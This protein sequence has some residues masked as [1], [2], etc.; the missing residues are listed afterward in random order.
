MP[1]ESPTEDAEDPGSGLDQ[2]RLKAKAK[3]EALIPYWTIVFK[4]PATVAKKAAEW[5]IDYYPELFSHATWVSIE[6]NDL[7]DFQAGGE[8]FRDSGLEIKIYQKEIPKLK[9][10]TLKLGGLIGLKSAGLNVSSPVY[11]T[12]GGV[13]VSAGIGMVTPYVNFGKD[14]KPVISFSAKVPLDIF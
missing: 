1:Y 11:T 2:A 14:W 13:V 8:G 5:L 6:K 3:L 9:K 7:A 10:V 12:T 4:D